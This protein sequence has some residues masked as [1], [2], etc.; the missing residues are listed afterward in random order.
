MGG[1][2]G[3][4]S[5]GERRD[6][7]AKG[8]RRGAKTLRFTSINQ[9]NKYLKHK[10]RLNRGDNYGNKSDIRRRHFEAPGEDSVRRKRGDMD[11]DKKTQNERNT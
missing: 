4:L 8:E 3:R 2:F 10:N 9:S 7:G 5:D 11:R 1:C 6:D